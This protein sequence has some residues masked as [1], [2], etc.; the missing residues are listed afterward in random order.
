MNDVANLTWENVDLAAGTLSFREQKTAKRKRGKAKETVVCLHRDLREWLETLPA[1]D[2]PD[3][4]LFPTLHGKPSGS[5][6]GLSNAFSRVMDRA[7]IRQPSTG[8]GA[9]TG[10]GRQFRALGFHFLP[11]RLRLP[12]G[13]R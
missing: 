9:R 6:G 3:A 7:R 10:K 8:G 2:T 12:A 13:E 1:G 4:P 5:H 11:P